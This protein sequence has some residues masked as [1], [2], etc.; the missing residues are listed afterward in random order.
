MTPDEQIAALWRTLETVTQ[1]AHLALTTQAEAIKRLEARLYEL[2]ANCATVMSNHA[3]CI[4]DLMNRANC[5]REV[6]SV[7]H[8]F[9]DSEFGTPAPQ[10]TAIAAIDA[11]I[12]NA[13]KGICRRKARG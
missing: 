3:Q 11:A 9:L 6:I 13:E 4:R 5:Q 1:T 2:D 8:D 12:E 10:A 7:I